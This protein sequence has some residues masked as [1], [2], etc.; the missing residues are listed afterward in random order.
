MK[1]KYLSY[2]PKPLLDDLVLGR[3]LPVLGAGMSRN[4]VVPT[5]KKMPR[6]DD[7][8][9]QLSDDL[10]DYSYA[11]PLDA[12]SAF[13][14][15]YGRPK[16]IEKLSDYLLVD[17]SRP[18][19]VHR[20]FCSIPFNM[21]CTTNIDFLL[22]RQYEASPRYCIPL[23]DEDQLSIN[24]RES[25][26][27]LLKLHGDLHHPNR[28]VV[29]EE[30][31]DSFLDRYPLLS[32]FLANLLI[33]RTAV[34][35]GY[36]LD[37]PDFR[38][39]WQVVTD[40]LGKSRRLA[41]SIT[42]GAR[43]TDL[44]RFERR[45]VKVI[46][47][48]GSRS[49][50]ANILTQAFDELRDYLQ[51]HVI[52]ASHVTT[53]DP[54]NELS[55]LRGAPTRLCFFA[56]PLSLHPFYREQVFPIVRK[57]GLVPVTADDVISTGENFL[58]KIDALIERALLVVID[59]STPFT[60]SEMRMALSRRD[61]R[62]VI[63]ISEDP[64]IFPVDLSQ[65]QAILR[66]NI[67]DVDPE[68]FLEELRTLFHSAA[69]R[70][71]PILE[72]EPMRLLSLREHRSAVISAIALLETMLRDRLEVQNARTIG[73]LRELLNMARGE[74]LLSGY[75]VEQIGTWLRV[76]NEVVHSH[77]SVSQATANEIVTGVLEIVGSIR[78]RFGDV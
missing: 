25:G 63:I 61:L 37:D 58:A 47:L 29:T 54:L 60:L 67:L 78:R 64:S 20:A 65:V 73:S 50:Y 3:W 18:G 6:W 77:S 70:Y 26:V 76:R 30:D 44:V 40:R 28:L 31:Y 32:T 69:A 17:E 7:L 13:D 5:G 10:R 46:N 52:L 41:Y 21:V 72:E 53:Q 38:Q 19:E 55:L 2:F 71:L 62:Q 43:P 39:V 48:P 35:V 59:A 33:T 66:P 42:V 14:H 11:G 34:L 74:N 4:A 68:Y 45:G 75:L 56:I 8:G 24:V 22:E 9:K 27:A 23:I 51:E 16:L 12:I 49:S 15:E 36:S 1:A 57:A